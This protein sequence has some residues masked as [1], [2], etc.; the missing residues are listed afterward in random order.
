MNLSNNLVS[1]L[2]LQREDGQPVDWAPREAERAVTPI[3]KKE[4]VCYTIMYKFIQFQ[5][6]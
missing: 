1:L 6:L 2:F 4:G 3:D 5:L